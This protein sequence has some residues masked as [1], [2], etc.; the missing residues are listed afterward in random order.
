MVSRAGTALEANC[1]S[2]YKDADGKVTTN[3][4]LHTYQYRP[5]TWRA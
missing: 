5:A 2:W 3:W 4:P 1:T